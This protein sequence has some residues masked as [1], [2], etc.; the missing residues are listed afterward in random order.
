L[1]TEPHEGL[2]Q[3][4][5]RD[6]ALARVFGS[7]GVQGG[8]HVVVAH[9]RSNEVQGHAIG[10]TIAGLN[11]AQDEVATGVGAKP[12]RADEVCLVAGIDVPVSRQR[13]VL[14]D[15]C[16]SARRS[17]SVPAWSPIT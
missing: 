9:E 7:G 14:A 2:V 3:K 11:G 16:G 8:E 4:A 13:I 17:D 12:V 6:A 5:Q 10:E 1:S 15:E